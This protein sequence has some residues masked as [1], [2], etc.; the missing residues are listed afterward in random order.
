VFQVIGDTVRRELSFDLI[1]RSAGAV[2][3]R[4]A[5]LDHKARNNSVKGQ[6][7]IEFLA[8]ELLKIF[9]GNRR[10]FGIKFSPHHITVFHFHYKLLHV[11]LRSF[12]VFVLV[13]HDIIEVSL[14]DFSSTAKQS[15]CTYGFSAIVSKNNTTKMMITN[16]GMIVPIVLKESPEKL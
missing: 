7:V 9:Y 13:C 3:A 2:A 10:D 5:A 14:S 6:T 4:A 16:E 15:P 11:I 1:A 8:C 12:K